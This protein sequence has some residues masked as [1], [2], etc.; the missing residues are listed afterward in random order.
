MEGTKAVLDFQIETTIKN[1][2]TS[3]CASI[4]KSE[5]HD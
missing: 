3:I 1:I 4:M 2:E 5:T